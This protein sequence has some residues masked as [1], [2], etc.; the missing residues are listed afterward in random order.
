[1]SE[2]G[3]FAASLWKAGDGASGDGLNKM[4]DIHAV[5]ATHGLLLRGCYSAAA[6]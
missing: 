6:M 4:A 3:G 1:M 2:L 5:N